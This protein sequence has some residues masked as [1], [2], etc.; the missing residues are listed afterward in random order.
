M[1]FS[2][3][4]VQ[5]VRFK[6]DAVRAMGVPRPVCAVWPAGDDKVSSPLII[7]RGEG[8][9]LDR[10]AKRYYGSVPQRTSTRPSRATQGVISIKVTGAQRFRC[11]CGTDCASQIMMITDAGTLRTRASEISVVGRNTRGVILNPHG[12]R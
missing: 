1:L 5:A 9:Y 8:A 6:E 11:R 2:P 10:N 7:P 12:G 3:A 4:A